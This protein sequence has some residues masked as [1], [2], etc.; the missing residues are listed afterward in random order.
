M[1][2]SRKMCQA[3]APSSSQSLKM[4]VKLS[5]LFLVTVVLIWKGTPASLSRRMPLREA[6]KAPLRQRKAS[7]VSASAASMEMDTRSTPAS[8]IFFAEASS[9]RVPLGEKAQM[10]PRS[11]A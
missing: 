4:R 11:W 5:R 9:M 6:A 10:W 3:A 2:T 7:C 8:R 1:G